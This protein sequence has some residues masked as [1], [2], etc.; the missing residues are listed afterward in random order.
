MKT[1]RRRGRGGRATLTT[2]LL[3]LAGLLVTTVAAAQ[4]TRTRLRADCRC[5]DAD[6]NEIEDCTCLRTPSSRDL[7]RGLAFYRDSRA[8]L[9]VSV[10]TDQGASLDARG[11]RVQSVTRDGPADDAGIRE[12]DVITS[13][14]GHSLLDALDTDTERGFDLDRSIPVQRLLAISRELEPGQEVEVRYERDG[15]T[16]T[17]TLETEDLPTW[18]SFQM[19]TPSW[20]RREMADRVREMGD[21]MRSF[22]LDMPQGRFRLWADSTDGSR[23]R[24]L[25]SPGAAVYFYGGVSGLELIELNPGLAG[26]FGVSGGVLVADVPEDSPLGLQPGD[27]VLSVGD[28]EVDS[29][30]HLRRILRSYDQ[31]EDITFRIMRHEREMSV[32]GHLPD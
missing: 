22:Q 19:T 20:E 15:E 8:R 10:S 3:A 2:S 9:G 1:M 26:Y 32:R 5:V 24:V 17:A 14:D 13:V 16:R 30:E 21:R 11:A 4:E 25:G 28:R 31:D 7:V 6:G 12:G 27:V 18:T 29:P 23:L